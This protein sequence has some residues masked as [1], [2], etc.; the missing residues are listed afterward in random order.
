MRGRILRRAKMNS[1]DTEKNV[2]DGALGAVRALVFEFGS[3]LA[4]VL[5]VRA[6]WRKFS[7]V[8][9]AN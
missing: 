3:M 1:A 8:P 4:C 5:I 9:Q 6:V 7:Q 2:G